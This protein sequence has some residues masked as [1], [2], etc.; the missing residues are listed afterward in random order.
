METMEWK[1]WEQEYNHLGCNLT[2]TQELMLLF[3]WKKMQWEFIYSQAVMT[4]DVTQGQEQGFSLEARSHVKPDRPADGGQVQSR[5]HH[6]NM[7]GPRS[8]Q[9]VYQLVRPRLKYSD[10]CAGQ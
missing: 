7:G 1:F 5:Q 4:L 6:C 9:E 8:S 2:M 10:H 3:L